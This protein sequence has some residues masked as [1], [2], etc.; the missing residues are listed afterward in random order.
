MFEEIEDDIYAVEN[1]RMKWLIE[2]CVSTLFRGE[3]LVG[4]L[5]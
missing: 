2:V 1:R 5:L 4:D 3:A